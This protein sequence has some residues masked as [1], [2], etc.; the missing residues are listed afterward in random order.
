MGAKDLPSLKEQWPRL[1]YHRHLM[2]A[3]QAPMGDDQQLRSWQQTFLEAYARQI[4]RDNPQAA[5]VRLRHYAHWPL[6]M[7]FETKART[8]NYGWQRAYQDFAR[9]MQNF[10]V[11]IDENGYELMME[12]TQR[13]SDLGPE[14]QSDQSSTWQSGQVE[15]AGRWRG[16]PR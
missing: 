15:T 5:A 8:D 14:S 7:E 16:G 10:D 12:V 13:R 2:L 3:D 4:L 6:P 1:R 11:R 9:V